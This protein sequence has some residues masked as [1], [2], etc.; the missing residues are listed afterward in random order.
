VLANLADR[1]YLN[2]ANVCLTHSSSCAGTLNGNRQAVC[3]KSCTFEGPYLHLLSELERTAVM[4]QGLADFVANR[5]EAEQLLRIAIR[6]LSPDTTAKLCLHYRIARVL[7]Q[8]GDEASLARHVLGLVDLREDS[9]FDL[10]IARTAKLLPIRQ[11][12]MLRAACHGL[13]SSSGRARSIKRMGTT[14]STESVFKPAPMETLR[15]VLLAHPGNQAVSR[16]WLLA[17]ASQCG[18]LDGSLRR[19]CHRRPRA[20][21]VPTGDAR[22]RPSWDWGAIRRQQIAFDGAA[23]ACS[24]R[25]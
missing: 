23:H 21:T 25:I 8:L 12:P 15:T 20:R 2:A 14:P 4:A 6:A 24:Y 5:R 1:A 16:A 13:Q 3:A 7:S 22:L 9:R 10:D 17:A 11:Y 18:Q 19:W